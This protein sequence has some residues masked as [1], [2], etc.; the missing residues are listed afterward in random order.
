M[1]QFL[2][3]LKMAVANIR[4]NKMRSLLTMLGII[5]GISSVILIM[6]VGNGAKNIIT[7]EMADIGIN[8]IAIYS[9]DD[10]NSYDIT[11]EDIDALYDG[12]KGIRAISAGYGAEGSVMT[13]KGEFKANINGK[14]PDYQ[15]FSKN[16]MLK[17]RYFTKKE[18]LAGQPLAIIGEKDAVRIFGSTDIVGK[19]LDVTLYGKEMGLTIIGVEKASEDSMFSFTY[20]NSP[21]ELQ[22]PLITFSTMYGMDTESFWQIMILTEEGEDTYRIA[23]EAS[24]LLERR[25]QCSG[26]DIYQVENFS[27]YMTTVDKVIG[28]VTTLVSFVAA[29]SLLVG[30]IGVMN[31]MLVSVTER[32]REIGIRKALG[33]KTKSIMLQ[34]LS[35][36][37]I[38]T[39][40]GGVVGILLGIGGAFGVAKVIAMIQPAFAFTPSVSPAAVLVTTL[41]SIGIG[42]FFGI[43]PA[44]KEFL[45]GLR[46]LCDEKDILL[47]FDE[48]QC[49]MGRTGSMF[50]WQGFGVKPD[51]LTMAKAIGNGIPVGAFAMT[52][53]VA[54]YSLQPGDHGATYGGNPLACTAVKTVIKIF[55]RDHIVDHVN[56]VAPYL[57]KRLDELVEELDCVTERKGKGLMQG[58]VVTK[59]LA[60]VNKRAIEE[61]ILIIQAQGNVIRFVP[62]LIVEE[63]HIDEMIEKLK[64]ALA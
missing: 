25:H 7:D 14:M 9:Y 16:G 43:Y 57:T 52:E 60:E 31:I 38:I 21:I 26:E 18:Y 27:D 5:I 32:T 20:E 1:S 15:Y 8:Q 39:L 46:K 11:Q 4:A 47:I 24:N 62:P 29:I 53:E 55:E 17:G 13:Q 22:I 49:G 2:E 54:K 10:T 61:G 56:A 28:I 40:I 6:S 41:F 23:S 44:K 59:P 12:V 19:E 30:G 50:A 51:I 58:I 45:E 33:A 48:V 63:K 42:I 35:E 36:S 34:F 64:R 37:A 3:Y